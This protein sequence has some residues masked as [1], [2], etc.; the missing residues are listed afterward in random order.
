MSMNFLEKYPDILTVNHIAEILGMK[1]DTIYR[2]KGL[3]R[4]RIGNGRGMIRYRKIDLESYIISRVE[5][6]VNI[7]ANQKKER[8]RKVGISDLL[9]WQEIQAIRMEYKG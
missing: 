9:T 7:D 4:V 6:E 3:E 1:P 5:V 2:M 8:Y